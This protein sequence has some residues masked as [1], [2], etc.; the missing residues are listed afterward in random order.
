MEVEFEWVILRE[1]EYEKGIRLFKHEGGQEP[2]C[3][4]TEKT[5]NDPLKFQYY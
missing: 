5:D 3:S 2:L 1:T 4:R